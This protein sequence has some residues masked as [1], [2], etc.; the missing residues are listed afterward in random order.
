M[1]LK[2]LWMVIWFGVIATAARYGV[3]ISAHI[4]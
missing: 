4:N 3:V 1:T 2:I